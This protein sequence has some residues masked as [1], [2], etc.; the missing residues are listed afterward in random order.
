MK[1]VFWRA[2][3]PK[4][5]M[6]KLNSLINDA[7]M[8]KINT[9]LYVLRYTTISEALIKNNSMTTLNR[10]IWMLEGLSGELQVKVFEYCCDRR[11]QMLEHDVN[12]EEPDFEDVRKVILKKAKMLERQKLF[13]EGQSAK[14]AV[15]TTSATS[16]TSTMASTIPMAVTSPIPSASDPVSELSKQIS[17]LVFFLEGQPHQRIMAPAISESNRRLRCMWCDSLNHTRRDCEGFSDALRSKVVG[18]STS[19]RIML[20]STGE[21][22]PLMMG[23]GGMKRLVH[24]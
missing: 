5:T 19:G 8:G 18:F 9:N 11:W 6:A 24:H 16:A 21:E 23:K 4:N 13:L 22:L 15:S 17:Q 10:V 14:S 12:T 20:L 1:E 3:S 7:K 2:D